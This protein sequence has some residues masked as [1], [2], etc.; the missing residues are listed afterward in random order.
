MTGIR[1]AARQLA[2]NPGFS[3]IV[4]LTLALGIGASALIYSVIDGVLLKPLPYPEPDRIV[5]VF[6]V[7]Q[8]GY[9]RVNLSDPNFHDLEEQARSFSALA[10]FGALTSPVLGGSEAARLD[11]AAVS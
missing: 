4:V 5:R 3:A 10:A 11:V 7:A 9:D 2:R 8:N 1:V 6:Q